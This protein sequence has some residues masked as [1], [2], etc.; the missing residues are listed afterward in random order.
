MSILLQF[1]F[2]YFIELTGN[3]VA[4]SILKSFTSSRLSYPLVRPFAN[5]YHLNQDEMAKPIGNYK[6]LQALFTR[7]LAEGVRPVDT[8]PYSLVSPVDGIVSDSGR[9]SS[10]QTFY[11]KNKLYRTEKILGSSEKAATYKGGY[12]FIIYLSP[13]HYHRMHY[14]IKGEL[15]S[16]WYLGGKS[17]PV[18]SLGERFGNHPFSTNYRVT[19]EISTDYGKVAIVKVGALNINSIE[20]THATTDFE[21]GD[22]LGY[23]SFGS[24]V[25]LFI[26]PSNLFQPTINVQ[27]EVEVGQPIGEWLNK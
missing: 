20:L 19:S 11:I 7:H 23:F 27:S 22:E 6:S 17:Y 9:I 4:S 21:K 2:K 18:N 24:T 5:V 14:P 25:I 15:L 16:R 12:F 3:P 10:N 1:L 13:R 26:E 8:S